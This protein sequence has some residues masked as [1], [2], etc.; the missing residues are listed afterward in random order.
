MIARE[1]ASGATQKKKVRS[2]SNGIRTVKHTYNLTKERYNSGWIIS[3]WRCL[4]S[5]PSNMMLSLHLYVRSMWRQNQMQTSL[6][7][8]KQ[9]QA[10][11]EAKK[12]KMSRL[13]SEEILFS[14]W[15]LGD[16]FEFMVTSYINSI[17]VNWISNYL[18][19][20]YLNKIETKEKTRENIR[21]F[22]FLKFQLRIRCHT[23]PYHTKAKRQRKKKRIETK[24]RKKP[25]WKRFCHWIWKND[26]ARQMIEP[27]LHKYPSHGIIRLLWFAEIYS[28]SSLKHMYQFVVFG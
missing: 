2:L 28:V 12:K 25:K 24:R 16:Q 5:L 1:K 20:Q 8:L 19:N 11:E 13:F 9:Q 17:Q 21:M 26:S 23:D 15:E 6:I 3:S 14:L 22:E 10:T 4:H 27:R 18:C 7:V